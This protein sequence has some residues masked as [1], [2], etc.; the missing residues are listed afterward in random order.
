MPKSAKHAQTKSRNYWPIAIICVLLFGVFMVSVSIS[1]ALKNPIQ[2]ENTYFSK[3]G[4]IDWRINDIIKEQNAFE[5]TYTLQTTLLDSDNKPIAHDSF[6]FP[7]TATANRPDI[8]KDKFIIPQ[9]IIFKATIMPKNA[10]KSVDKKPLKA[11]L[12]LDSMHLANYLQDLGELEQD[13]ANFSKAL[14]LAPGRWKFVLEISYEA[15]KKA[16]FESQIFVKD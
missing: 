16:Y 5:S 4:D 11:H 7:Y 6:S 2:D 15:D 9:D 10:Q 12:F 8:K 1:I 3:K 13:R 14:H